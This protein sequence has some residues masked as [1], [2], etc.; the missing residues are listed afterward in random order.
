MKVVPRDLFNDAN[1]LM[2]FGNL[3]IQLEK[4]NEHDLMQSN[5]EAGDQFKINMDKSDGSTSIRGVELV[6]DG[7][8]IEVWRPLNTREKWSLWFRGEE[9][10]YEVFDDEGNLSVELLSLINKED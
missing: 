5:V 9:D 6:I 7:N 4:I 10:D 3:Y 8:I 2:N 1:I